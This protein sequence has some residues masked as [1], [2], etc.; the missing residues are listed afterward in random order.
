VLEE[1]LWRIV[2]IGWLTLLTVWRV[3]VQ[4]DLNTWL[5]NY[6]KRNSWL[7]KEERRTRKRCNHK[8]TVGFT[9]GIYDERRLRCNHCGKGLGS[10]T[11]AMRAKW[12]K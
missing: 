12:L 1:W 7:T 8:G 5:E 2:V 10:D 4:F 11:P 9:T 3:K 6:Q